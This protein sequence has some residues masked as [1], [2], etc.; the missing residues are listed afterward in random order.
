MKNIITHIK[1]SNYCSWDQSENVDRILNQSTDIDLTYNDN[2][3]F[4]LT[5]KHNNT[6]ILGILLNYYEK[7]QLQGDSNSLEY[8]IAKH[9]LQT[10]LQEAV[11]SVDIS[12]EMQ[13][14][15]DKYLPKEEDSDL[16]LDDLEDIQISYFSNNFENIELT[17]DNL[18]KLENNHDLELVGKDHQILDTY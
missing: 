13:I 18:K 17:E 12:E 14:V 1:L 9:K 10:V 8:K 16:E 6:K 7:T 4:K 15:L 3:Y 2:I 11:N 5:I